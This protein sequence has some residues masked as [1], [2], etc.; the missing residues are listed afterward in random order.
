MVPY[1]RTLDQLF[2][3]SALQSVGVAKV[4]P[5]T[6]PRPEVIHKR[7][8]IS[9]LRFRRFTLQK[10]LQ[11]LKVRSITGRGMLDESL[12]AVRIA[13]T[14]LANALENVVF[15]LDGDDLYIPIGKAMCELLTASKRWRV[16]SAYNANSRSTR[17]PSSMIARRLVFF[18]LDCDIKT[19]T[20]EPVST[21]GHA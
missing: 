8:P 16:S 6:A 17:S 20:S 4:I 19:C 10:F 13:K 11:V 12:P 14:S 18:P 15:G 1:I 7:A 2:I 5:D 21:D 3:T 9:R